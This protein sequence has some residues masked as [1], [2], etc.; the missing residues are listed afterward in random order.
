MAQ[1]NQSQTYFS[2]LYFQFFSK[3]VYFKPHITYQSLYYDVY[4]TWVTSCISSWYIIKNNA[5]HSERVNINFMRMF[6][7]PYTQRITLNENTYTVVIHC[8]ESLKSTVLST[9]FLLLTSLS[10]QNI[11]FPALKSLSMQFPQL[12]RPSPLLR[13]QNSYPSLNICSFIYSRKT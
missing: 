6:A 10:Y 8:C 12:E 11:S 9:L 4:N 2:S 3:S 7:F 13:P 5:L 1:Y